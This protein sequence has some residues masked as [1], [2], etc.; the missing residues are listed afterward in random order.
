MKK[1]VRFLRWLCDRLHGSH[2]PF[3]DRGF[4][5]DKKKKLK[6]LEF[7]NLM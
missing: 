3:D 5:K 6:K 2:T 7:H 1:G 4:D